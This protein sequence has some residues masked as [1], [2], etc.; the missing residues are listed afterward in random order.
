MEYDLYTQ[1]FG[2]RDQVDPFC[3]SLEAANN[4]PIMVEG[5]TWVRIQTD[6]QVVDQVEVVVTHGPVSLAVSTVLG[7]N[8]LK[9]LD[10]PCLL[11]KFEHPGQRARGCGLRAE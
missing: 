8:V 6:D 3:L 5:V 7:I 1:Q 9:D 2:T 4:L 10:L 11:V